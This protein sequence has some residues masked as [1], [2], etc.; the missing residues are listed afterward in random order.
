MRRWK[1]GRRQHPAKDVAATAADRLRHRLDRCTAA[2]DSTPALE[3]AALADASAVLDE[4]LGDRSLANAAAARAF[5]DLSLLHRIRAIG[6]GDSM[7]ELHACGALQVLAYVVDPAVVAPQTYQE[8]ARAI[9]GGAETDR[10]TARLRALQ[11]HASAVRAAW[12]RQPHPDLADTFVRAFQ[13]LVAAAGPDVPNW[14]TR[15]I[16]L[17][18]ALDERYRLHEPDGERSDLDDAIRLTDEAISA[19]GGDR[20]VLLRAH[21]VRAPMLMTRDELTP[22]STD[23]TAAAESFGALVELTAPDD[24]AYGRHQANLAAVRSLLRGAEPPPADPGP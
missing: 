2:Q 4:V 20:N 15:L 9:T 17:A 23:L 19:A 11:G 12:L 16:D 24:P 13:R 18:A 10:P 6:F 14:P 3:P 5:A 22:G 1:L 8:V 7:E 21:K